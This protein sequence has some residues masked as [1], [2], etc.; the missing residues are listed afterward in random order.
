MLTIHSQ[1]QKNIDL[2]RDPNFG[3]VQK[4]VPNKKNKATV[5]NIHAQWK[6]LIEEQQ[7]TIKRQYD[8]GLIDW[9]ECRSL[10]RA[11]FS[12]ED[13]IYSAMMNW[14][15]TIDLS[16]TLEVEYLATF[17][18]IVSSSDYSPNAL[19][20]LKYHQTI[21]TKI[22]ELIEHQR[23][24]QQNTKIN[25]VVSGLIELYFYL[26][27]GSYTPD[28]IK[29]YELNKV[30]IALLL[31]SFYRAF[32][33]EDSNLIMGIFEEFHPDVINEFTQL[34]HSSIV[35]HARNSSYGWM[36]S[37]LLSMLAKPA[38]VFYKNA[39][40]IFKSLINDFDFSDIEMDYLIENLILC[41]LGIEGKKTQQA[42]IQEHLNHIKAKGA[43]QSIINDYQQKLDN[44][45]S[46][47]QEKYNKN[48]KTALRRITVSAPTRKSLGI[49]LKA[50]TDK[51]KVTHLKSLLLEADALKNTPKLFNI[52]NKPTVLFRDFNFK[53]LVIEELMYRQE[54][55]LPKFDLDLFAKEYI[56]REI[57]REE[58]GYE[59]IAEVK[60]YFK[61]VEIPMTLL[62]KVTQLY[63]DS[64]LNGGAVF[65]EHMHP[66][67]DPGMGDEV[68]KVTNKA[69]D[70]L[71]LLPNLTK[72]IG[73]ENSE[74][75]K[76]LLNALA[77]RNIE[78]EEEE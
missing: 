77:E 5:R 60:K 8:R 32:S 48:I 62:E 73:L 34:L 71:A 6:K 31:P 64:G 70:D 28:F 57:D 19:V 40:L 78:L 16:D 9:P 65:L 41:P 61:N 17:I 33:D 75:S 53:L 72:I 59:C 18:E 7:A 22:K 46:V 10:M 35:R 56:K 51:A 44:I 54:I 52:N 25:L 36:H 37:E 13:E 12:I 3:V 30:D 42:H 21:L 47:S 27:V 68:P 4:G 11:D 66:F 43:K 23:V 55:L 69:I 76:K 49:L 26:S 15:S 63:Q 74:P 58:D 14:L 38:D 1:I 29:R 45:D 20:L 39:P 24:H 50:T 67:W 2:I